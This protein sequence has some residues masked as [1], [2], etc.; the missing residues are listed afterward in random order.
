MACLI[1]LAKSFLSMHRKTSVVGLVAVLLGATVVLA[2]CGQ[3]VPFTGVSLGEA[4]GLGHV[5]P[6]P[7]AP[8]ELSA[9]IA[10]AGSPLQPNGWTNAS[11]LELAATTVSK[12]ADKLVLEVEFLPEEQPFSGLPNVVGQPG[13]TLVSSPTMDPG[14]QYHWAARL[15]DRLGATSAWVRYDGT[16]GFQPTPPPAPTIQALTHGGWVG[17]RQ[18]QLSWRAQSDPA[19]IAGFAYSL[20]QQPT[21]AVPARVDTTSPQVSVSA[22]RD[23]DWYLHVRTLD[24]AGNASDAATLPIHIDSAQL[25][26]EAP[27]TDQDGAWN[28]AVGPMTV[29]LKAS[30]A[31]QLS[32]AILPETGDTPL[33]VI[34]A[35]TK[36]E[37]SVQWD[38]KDG[39]GQLVPPGE[40][41]LEARAEDQTGR[42]AQTLADDTIQVTDKRIVV[43]LGQER[44][45]AY[46]GDKVFVDTLVTT[47]GPE[48]PTPTGTF[49]ILGKY[50]PF[51]FK[52]PWPKSSPYWYP[53]SPTRY[54]MLFD[55]DG[56]FIHDAPWRSWFGP[57]S[58]A[59]DGKPGGDGTGTHGCV[60]VPSGVQAKLFGWTDVGTP[61]IVQN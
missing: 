36:N 18:L 57:G 60:N 56:Y 19:G 50:S 12:P 30:K 17:T 3:P 8:T 9:R 20:D 59:T 35:G 26:V 38:G 11:T 42:T 29:Q 4:I 45:I 58:N 40:Y 23:G 28:P 34:Q 14:E 16:I 61:V 21:A 47:G 44:M 22:T 10:G 2:S 52:S 1:M 41:R 15:R 24:N 27:K 7:A 31:S 54:A 32:L 33:R 6:G 53:D 55:N 49:H 37:A 39:K 43:F 13:E 5:L 51:T 25:T 46:Q 48:L